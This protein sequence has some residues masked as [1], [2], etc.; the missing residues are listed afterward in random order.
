[1]AALVSLSVFP[2]LFIAGIRYTGGTAQ[3]NQDALVVR[4]DEETPI[5]VH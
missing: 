1:M 3:S 5:V 2:T 4:V